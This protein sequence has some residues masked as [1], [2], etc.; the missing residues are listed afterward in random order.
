MKLY[1]D[2]HAELCSQLYNKRNTK[3]LLPF[4]GHNII[5]NKFTIAVSIMMYVF[6]EPG[7][8]GMEVHGLIRLAKT[9]PR[10]NMP[11]DE[12]G[13]EKVRWSYS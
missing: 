11:K 3:R 10:P 4:I 6:F 9:V 7:T 13:F 5:I 8:A 2:P 1:I 12:H